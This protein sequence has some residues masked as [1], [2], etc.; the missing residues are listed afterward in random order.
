M[1]EQNIRTA[2]FINGWRSFCMLDLRLCAIEV[3]E[4]IFPGG[5]IKFKP[6]QKMELTGLQMH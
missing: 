1:A 2:N 3:L 5:G 4:G 6:C